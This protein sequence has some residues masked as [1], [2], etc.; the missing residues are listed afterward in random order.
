M[1]ENAVGAAAAVPLVP[2][3]EIVCR[4]CFKAGIPIT[5]DKKYPDEIDPSSG[6]IR[7]TQISQQDLT[8]R[9]FSLQRVSL[10]SR[11]LAAAQPVRK[12]LARKERGLEPAGF[13][14]QGVVSGRVKEIHAVRDGGGRTI[15]C[16]YATPNDDSDAHAEVKFA[17]GVKGSEYIKWRVVLV[18][19]LGTLQP[20]E[21]LPSV[22][23]S[24][25]E[26]ILK[27]IE[28]CRASFAKL[29]TQ[30]LRR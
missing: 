15:F 28:V 11:Q 20:V 22:S 23:S 21:S 8:K 10:Y 13:V 27:F 5:V 25:G 7:A 16:V 2:D 30:F 29:L 26:R 12:E 18:D 9:G 14:L 4:L 6:K 19:L 17:P 1:G 24:L 3:H